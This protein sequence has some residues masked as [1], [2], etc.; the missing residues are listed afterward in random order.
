M[1]TQQH[2]LVI[3]ASGSGQLTFLGTANAQLSPTV[4]L[5]GG[6]VQ[7]PRENIYSF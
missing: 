1:V 6:L 5:Q 7:R 3:T 4:D 2:P